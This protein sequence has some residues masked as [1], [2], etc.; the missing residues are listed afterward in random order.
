MIN[1]GE[2]YSTRVKD[3]DIGKAG[4]F[5]LKLEN[6]NNTFEINP[7]VAERSADFVITV[8]DNTLIDYEL[9]KS[10][11]FKVI[12]MIYIY[13]II[14]FVNRY[15]LFRLRFPSSIHRFPSSIPSFSIIHSIVFHSIIQIVAQEVGPATNLSALVPVTISLRDVNDNSP[16]FDQESYEVT[17]SENV[18][19]GSRVTQV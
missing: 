11:S 12:N 9:Y 10:L 17:L 8:R 3:E 16:I 6:N 14:K 19:E 15:K 18:T 13:S 4:V 1:F 2:Q 7:T 5:T